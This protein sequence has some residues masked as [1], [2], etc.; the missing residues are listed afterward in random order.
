MVLS[1]ADIA[2]GWHTTLRRMLAR[3]VRIA[4]HTISDDPLRTDLFCLVLCHFCARHTCARAER[5]VPENGA[6]EITPWLFFAM[7]STIGN[8]F[9]LLRALIYAAWRKS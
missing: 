8:L 3:H 1:T 2:R 7:R 4:R 9:G 6:A 5:L